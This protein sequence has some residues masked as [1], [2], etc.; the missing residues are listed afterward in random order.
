MVWTTHALWGRVGSGRRRALPGV[1]AVIAFRLP[2]LE[3]GSPHV[4]VG[5]AADEIVNACRQQTYLRI[6]MRQYAPRGRTI[7]A[8]VRMMILRSDTTDQ[9]ST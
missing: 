5:G 2:R 6:M 9:F 8:A 7:T 1:S 3:R 4:V